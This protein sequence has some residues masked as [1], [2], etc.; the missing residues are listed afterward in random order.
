METLKA[1]DKRLI[2]YA[3]DLGTRI[4]DAFDSKQAVVREIHASRGILT[5]K[6][7]PRKPAPTPSATW[8]RRP[9]P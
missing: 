3:V 5:T 8:T 1:G 7:P 6:R 4:T 9:R 2:S